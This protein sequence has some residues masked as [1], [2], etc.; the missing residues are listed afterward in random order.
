MS[1]TGHIQRLWKHCLWADE[2]LFTA[3]RLAPERTD[4]WR[5]YAHIL[6][7]EEV[8][9]ARLQDRPPAVGVWP[10]LSSDEIGA[11]RQGVAT[12]CTA[13]VDG[14]TPDS[15]SERVSYVNSD[16]ATFENTIEEILLQVLLHGQY[17]RGKVNLLLR[18][19]GCA[20]APLDYIAFVRGSPAAVTAV[21]SDD[22][23]SAGQPPA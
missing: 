3:V 9:L 2:L 23:G 8:W 17:H 4:V 5:E 14:L 18:Q 7:V 19:N 20:P 6:A 11:L 22:S 16:G 1:D 10:V 13:Y 12:A 21:D 15:L